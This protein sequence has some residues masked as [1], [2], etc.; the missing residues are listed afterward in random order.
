M[1][2]L[3]VLRPETWVKH[4]EYFKAVDGEIF[5][6]DLITKR[7]VGIQFFPECIVWTK[8]IGSNLPDKD[9]L[10]G[11]DVYQQAKRLQILPDGVRFKMLSK[12]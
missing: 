6:T 11:F 8:V 2:N 3:A 1:M 7:P 12:P 9:L 4:I 5:K 10:I